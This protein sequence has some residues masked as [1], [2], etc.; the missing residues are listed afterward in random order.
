M[1]NRFHTQT[2]PPTALCFE[3]GFTWTFQETE[4]AT[5]DVKSFFSNFGSI[6]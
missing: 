3:V 6:N 5:A 4:D 2:D 1:I